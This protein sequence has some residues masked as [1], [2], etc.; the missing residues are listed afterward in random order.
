MEI[1]E[2]WDR[3]KVRILCNMH[4]WTCIWHMI[5]IILLCKTKR[6]YD[7]LP[8]GFARQNRFD[9]LNDHDRLK[10]YKQGLNRRY[11][12][13]TG[14]E[15]FRFLQFLLTHGISAFKHVADKTWHQSVR[16]E[17]SWPLFCQIWIIFAHLKLL[18]ASARRNWMICRLEG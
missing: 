9:E 7:L 12:L 16:F 2:S 1:R 13:T 3:I 14:T 4:P 15:Y 8:F 18:I 6:Q 5:I 10:L 17:N 11:P